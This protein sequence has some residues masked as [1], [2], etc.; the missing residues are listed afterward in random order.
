MYRVPSSVRVVRKGRKIVGDRATMHLDNGI[1]ND[2]ANGIA[3]ATVSSSEITADRHVVT[4]QKN[5]IEEERVGRHFQWRGD[6]FG[7][8]LIAAPKSV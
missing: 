4:T 2:Q 6:N 7:Q 1:I 3:K 8:W 5:G